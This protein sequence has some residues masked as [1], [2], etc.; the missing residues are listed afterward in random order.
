M[1]NRKISISLRLTYIIG[2]VLYVIS[3]RGLKE[4]GDGAWNYGFAASCGCCLFTLAT[5]LLF[6]IKRNKK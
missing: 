2:F 5:C 6:Y 1:K 3:M 4:M